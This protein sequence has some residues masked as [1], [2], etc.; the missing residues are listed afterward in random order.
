MRDSENGKIGH[1][2]KQNMRKSGISKKKHA[3]NFETEKEPHRTSCF[4]TTSNE[5]VTHYTEK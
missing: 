5:G 3:I 1:F 4:S 2:K